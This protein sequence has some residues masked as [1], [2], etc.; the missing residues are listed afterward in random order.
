M[1]VAHLSGPRIPTEP[2]KHISLAASIANTCMNNEFI[3]IE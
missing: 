2:M 3:N 1:A